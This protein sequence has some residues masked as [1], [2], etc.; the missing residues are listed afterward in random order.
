MSSKT[1]NDPIHGHIELSYLACKVIDT[2][3]FQRLRDISQL[4]GVYFVFPGAASKRFEHSLGVAH[5]AK[6]FILQLKKTQPELPIS[7]QDV[8]C[9]ELAGLCHDI[10]HGPFSHLFDGKVLP[11]LMAKGSGSHDFA[12]EHASIAIFQLLI[13]ENNLLPEFRAA[14]L[15][16]ADIHFVQELIL[17]DR[18]EAPAEFQWVGRGPEKSFLYDIVANKRNGI[19]VDKFDYFARDCHVLGVTK[20]FDASRLMKF[21]RVYPVTREVPLINN[22]HANPAVNPGLNTPQQSQNTSVPSFETWSENA[23]LSAAGSAT[24][25]N[26]VKPLQIPTPVSA[27]THSSSER[28]SLLAPTTPKPTSLTLR[29]SLEICFHYKEAWNI[30]ELF[31][32]RYALHKRAYQHKIASAVE[33]MIAEALIL[34]DPHITIPGKDG[35]PRRMSECPHD[36]HAYWRLGEY[37]LRSIQHS[38]S[39]ELKPSRD[40][41]ERLNKRDLFSCVGEVLLSA[42]QT[43]SVAKG[44]SQGVKKHLLQLKDRVLAGSHE[45]DNIAS[46][47]ADLEALTA[48][49]LFCAVVK[50]GYGKGGLNPVSQ[51]TTFYLPKKQDLSSSNSQAS[52]PLTDT[53]EIGVVPQDS[54]SRL[55]PREY[56][57]TYVRVFCRRKAQKGC[58]ESLFKA[59]CKDLA[60]APD[61]LAPHTPTSPAK[62]NK[63]KR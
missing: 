5:L 56:E 61:T 25:V 50:V 19:D 6:S 41:I 29:T 63:R 43:R 49:D 24:A 22:T 44:G 16:Q 57:E 32:T 30:F 60:L 53:V 18:E 47:G 35:A 40:L 26:D 20:S 11:R 34:A 51:L 2:P 13:E 8:L 28:L 3:Q 45:Q 52:V 21:A 46:F 42:D 37:L 12:H 14:G 31:H 7:D 54:V 9:I 10:G 62:S 33:L 59:W 36:M 38:F 4:G 17:G 27:R 23:K 15:D 55:I 39:L 1:F 48:D 58:A